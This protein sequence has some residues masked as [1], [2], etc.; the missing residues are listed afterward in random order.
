MVEKEYDIVIIGSGAGGGTVAK[1]LS[2]L[3][4]DGV[5]IAVLEW[6]AKLKPEEYTGRELEMADRLMFDGGGVLTRDGSI[7][8]AVGNAYGGSTVTYTGTSFVMTEQ[9]L[10]KWN[11]PGLA[12]DDLKRRSEKYFAECNVHLTPPELINENNRKF[13]AA[14]ENL[15]IGLDQFPVNIKNC[16]GAGVCNLGCPNGAKMGTHEV[17]LPAAE[18]N[19][20]EVITNCKVE[21]L[22]DRECYATV[23]P[24]DY[25]VPSAWEPG[26]YRIKAKVIVACGGAIHTPALLLRS[27]LPARLPLLGRYFTLHPALI[28]VGQHERPLSNFYGH[29]KCYYTEHFAAEKRFILETCMYY[30]LSTAKSLIGFGAEHSAMMSRMDRLQM[31]IALAFDK[32]RERNRIAIDKRGEPV[33]DYRMS[34]EVLRALYEAQKVSA[35]ILFAAGAQKVHAPAG[36][37]FFI[38][39]AEQDKLDE[40]IAWKQMKLGKLSVASAHPMGGCRMGRDSSDSVT[41]EWGQVH[42]LPWLFVGDAGLFPRCAEVNPYITIMA[43]ADRVA[44]KIKSSAK[45]LLSS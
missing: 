39:A 44:E 31:I 26:K 25:G 20:V 21:R 16:Q 33:I 13:R 22:G 8:M 40:L 42:G 9:T 15:G 41:D 23:T 34:P 18:K 37:K 35:R 30:P 32:A 10:A 45:E 2:P 38:D 5:R 1:E 11:V 27:Q 43:L 17:Q 6:G 12:Y 29:P 7:T 28:L 3:C 19:G 36:V 14:C 24:R 4:R